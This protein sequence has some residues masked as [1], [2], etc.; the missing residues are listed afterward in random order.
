MRKVSKSIITILLMFVLMT[1]F[2]VN[3]IHQAN[4]EGSGATF[5]GNIF[6]QGVDTDGDGTYDLLEIRV[7]VNVAEAGDYIVEVIGLRDINN[8]YINVEDSQGVSLDNGIQV[9][10]LRLDGTTIYASGLNPINISYISLTD[11]EFNSFRELKDVPLSREYLYTEFNTPVP[12]AKMPSALSCYISKDTITQGESIVVSG[13][14]NVTLSGK[15][16]TLTYRKPDGSTMNRT[17]TTGS[18]G[19][20]S[21]SYIPDAAGSWSVTASW[22][23]DSAYDGATSS[24]RSLVVNSVTFILFTPF[25]MALLGGVII[26]IIIVIVVLR[27]GKR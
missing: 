1:S 14:I 15:T 6:D 11:S 19:S 16:V 9:V 24:M 10:Y 3:Q 5:T 18:D 22:T 12:V 27:R 20:Y 23:G 8:A 17:V 21:D 7:E 4:A 2:F 25:G 26:L 13:S